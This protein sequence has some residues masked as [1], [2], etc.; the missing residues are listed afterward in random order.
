MDRNF[1]IGKLAKQAGVNI[2]TIRYYERLGLLTPVERRKTLHQQPGYRLYD[3]EALKR[4]HFIR[5]AKEMGFTLREIGELLG[6]RVDSGVDCDRVRNQ[7]EAK[8][9]AIEQKMES[10]T[11]VQRVL[12]E[13]IN[14]CNKRLPTE[15]CPILRS[16]EKGGEDHVGKEKG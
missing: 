4:L 6:L 11:S 13:L 16:I 12:K 9:R 1:T 2:Q 14:M 15:G 10:L 5:Q 7:A 3:Q 8:L